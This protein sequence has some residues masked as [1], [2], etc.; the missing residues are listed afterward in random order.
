MSESKKHLKISSWLVLLLTLE[1]IVNL[2]CELAFG[3]INNAQIPEGSPEN[4]LL[5]TKIFII[6]VATLILIPQIYIGIKGLCVVKKPTKSKLHIYLAIV[7]FAISIASLMDPIL[8][9]V[10]AT[11]TGNAIGRLLM[12]IFEAIVY[13]DYIKYARAVA[14]GK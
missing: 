11:D 2:I 8:A 12:I 6:V 10:N 13:F 1:T 3:E 4:I 14:K 5:I 9:I 7:L